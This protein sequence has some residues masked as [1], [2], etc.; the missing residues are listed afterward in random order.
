MRTAGAARII[1]T[2]DVARI[3]PQ[4]WSNISAALTVDRQPFEQ[5]IA[6]A[7][8]IIE[9]ARPLISNWHIGYIAE[10][11]TAVINQQITRLAISI[12]PRSAKSNIVTVLWPCWSWI[13]RA[14]MRWI[15]GSYSGELAVKHS[16]SRRRVLGSDWY[17]DRWG[18]M[19]SVMED[20]NKQNSFENSARG[21]MY[22]TGRGGTITGFGADIIVLD[23]FLNPQ[24]AESEAERKHAISAYEHTFSSRLD[25]KKKGAIVVVAQRTHVN[26]LT[27]HVLKEGGWTHLELPAIAEKRTTLIFPL[28]GKTIVREV[29]DVL[30]PQREDKATLDKQ[31][32]M[33]GSRNWAAQWLCA[34][35]SDSGNMVK[36]HWWKFY[37]DDPRQ[38]AAKMDIM[39]QSWDFAFKD[40]ETSSWVV[41]LIMGK[42]G[43][44]KYIFAEYRD[45]MDL[46]ETC[47]A[48]QAASIAWPTTA[49]KFYED[50][51][52][53]PAVK[54]TLQKKIPGL[55]PVEP[56]GSKEARMS[57]ASPD[58]ES[59][60]VLLPYPFDDNGNPRPDRQWV[61]DY[62][63]EMAHF[64]EEPNDRGDATSQGI[65]KLNAVVIHT[66]E[67]NDGEVSILDADAAGPADELGG[68]GDLGG[69]F[70]AG[71]F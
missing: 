56:T 67:D 61:L 35:S 16:L 20:Q 47:K 3:R 14:W 71:N 15:F 13:E 4:L 28:S 43:A 54:S 38:L 39:A 64:P 2:G 46:V 41:G 19:F 8:P 31:K 17:R 53:G 33:S 11:L 27:G 10:H 63:E 42:K 62:I 29:G 68:Y 34:P 57:A 26:D 60:N 51:A 5:F 59:G 6:E 18:R 37:K 21:T 40:L 55:I 52:N 65:V 44:D 32:I 45:H 58:I 9:P 22:A 70:D 1:A 69:G 48:V 12:H 24:E 50:R 36:S 25:D 7:W 23:D 30:N 66:I 49:L